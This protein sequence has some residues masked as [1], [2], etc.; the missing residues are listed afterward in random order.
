MQCPPFLGGPMPKK[1]TQRC[2]YC[3][4]EFKPHVRQK[5]KQVRCYSEECKKAHKKHLNQKVEVRAARLENNFLYRAHN[6]EK[7]S[8]R[9]RKYYQ[10]NKK[11]FWGIKKLR[12][13]IDIL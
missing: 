13:R 10:K 5:E 8:E 4:K 7:I 6:K 1:E 2:K 3:R 11:K 12:S 9:N